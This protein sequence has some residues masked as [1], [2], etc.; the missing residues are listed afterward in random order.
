V[1]FNRLNPRPGSPGIALVRVKDGTAYLRV[2]DGEQLTQRMGSTG[3]A[4]YLAEATFTLTS[5]EEI[6]RVH[7]GF[8]EGDHANPGF[9]ARPSF[10]GLF[11]LP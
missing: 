7:V 8:L 9:Y 1:E 4:C 2:V 6:D 10:M 3:A 11:D 5:L